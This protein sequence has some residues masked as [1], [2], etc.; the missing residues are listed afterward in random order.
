ML[1]ATVSSNRPRAQ[2]YW[3]WLAKRMAGAPQ[4]LMQDV[5]KRADDEM[6]ENFVAGKR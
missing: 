1:A 2:A 6:L 5:V 3:S 4:K